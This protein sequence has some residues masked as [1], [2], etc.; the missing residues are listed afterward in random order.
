MI[1]TQSSSAWSALCID[2]GIL[3]QKQ[4]AAI[5]SPWL[6]LMK[7]YRYIFANTC[8]KITI[9]RTIVIVARYF[10]TR[11]KL[12]NSNLTV[13]GAEHPGGSLG[14][15]NTIVIRSVHGT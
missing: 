4:P 10:I 13:F 8:Q 9:A 12:I 7:N 15:V 5:T 3:L 1:P 14:R 2:T 6:F 11:V